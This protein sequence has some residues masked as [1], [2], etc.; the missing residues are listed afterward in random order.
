MLRRITSA[1]SFAFTT[2]LPICQRWAQAV[3][4]FM[5]AWRGA[6]PS[7]APWFM[8]RRWRMKAKVPT[9]IQ[10][11]H[12]CTQMCEADDHLVHCINDRSLAPAA[13][14]LSRIIWFMSFLGLHQ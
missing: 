5:L 6:I 7:S 14:I 2:K 8:K 9:R 3:A 1:D 13:L 11:T 10:E 12:L 4:I